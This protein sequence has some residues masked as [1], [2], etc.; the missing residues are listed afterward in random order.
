MGQ[1]SPLRWWK[2]PKGLNRSTTVTPFFFWHMASASGDAITI[3]QGVNLSRIQFRKSIVVC[4]GWTQSNV[5][6][7]LFLLLS[8]AN[9][10]L[11]PRLHSG[12]SEKELDGPFV[13]SSGVEVS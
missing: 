3:T 2:K 9:T 5:L 4:A 11:F 12:L 1:H 8:Y 6:Q 10:S 7:G 13:V